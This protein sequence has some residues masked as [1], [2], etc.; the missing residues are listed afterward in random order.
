MATCQSTATRIPSLCGPLTTGL[1]MVSLTSNFPPS[2]YLIL[3]VLFV[4][5]FFSVPIFAPVS[6]LSIVVLTN[7]SS[8]SKP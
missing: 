7:R 8:Y 1:S 5:S 4:L 6:K 2:S 3:S